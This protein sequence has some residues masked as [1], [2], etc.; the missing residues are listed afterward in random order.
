M[1]DKAIFEIGDIIHVK[2]K[3]IVNRERYTPKEIIESYE[4]KLFKE[5]HPELCWLAENGR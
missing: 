3:N 4:Y 2:W 5:E 1:N